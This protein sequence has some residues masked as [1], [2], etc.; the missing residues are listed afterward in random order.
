MATQQ[1]MGSQ[2]TQTG[3]LVVTITKQLSPPQA[4]PPPSPLEPLPQESPVSPP[5]PYSGDLGK[6]KGFLLECSLVFDRQP[7]TYSMDRAKVSYAAGLLRGRALDWAEAVLGSSTVSPIPFVH[8]KVF[9]HL[10][11]VGDV[12]EPLL[13]LRQVQR[14]IAN[15]S[16]EFRKLAAE[17]G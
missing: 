12:A 13:N 6:C 4:S 3:R 8:F 2:V 9:D 10:V 1:S 7:N 11:C 15:Y 16:V 14:S 17:C 5:E